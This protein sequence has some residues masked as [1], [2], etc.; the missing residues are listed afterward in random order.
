MESTNR[1]IPYNQ[2]HIDILTSMRNIYKRN[3]N[4]ND[5]IKIGTRDVIKAWYRK[6]TCTLC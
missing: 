2:I 6:N 1:H 4:V 3:E 5:D